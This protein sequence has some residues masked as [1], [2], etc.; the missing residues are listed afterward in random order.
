MEPA[1]IG[2]QISFLGVRASARCVHTLGYS[3][4]TG[5]RYWMSHGGREGGGRSTKRWENHA[6]GYPGICYTGIDCCSI[7]LNATF[8]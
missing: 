7:W 4:Y 8:Q 1:R 2:T 5:R 6:P 3:R